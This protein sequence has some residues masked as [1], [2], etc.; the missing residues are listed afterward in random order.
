MISVSSCAETK[1]EK[2]YLIDTTGTMEHTLQ[3]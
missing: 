3:T 2:E 1:I